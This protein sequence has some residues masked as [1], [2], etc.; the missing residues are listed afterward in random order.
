MR[1]YRSLWSKCWAD[2]QPDLTCSTVGHEKT[3]SKAGFSRFGAVGAYYCN[4]YPN[5]RNSQPAANIEAQA[6]KSASQT[7]AVLKLS[8]I[9]CFLPVKLHSQR[10]VT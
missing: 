9:F 1:Q 2:M 6:I 4:A 5:S 10:D 3:R 8:F 7:S